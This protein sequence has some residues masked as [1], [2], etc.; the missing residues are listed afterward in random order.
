VKKS[1]LHYLLP[2][3]VLLGLVVSLLGCSTQKNTA[4]RRFYHRWTAYFNYYFNAQDAYH[5][6]ERNAN[7][8][9]RYD[10]TRPLPLCLA[11]LPEA[12]LEVGGGMDRAIDKCATLIRFH[13]ITAKPERPRG[14]LDREERAF[15]AQ[16]EYN[17]YARK[18]WLLIGKARLW[19]GDYQQAQQA[20]EFS[21]RQFA[22]LPEGWEAELWMARL[23]ALQ[24]DT[25]S[26]RIRLAALA[27]SP[28]RP[29]GKLYSYN[30][31]A[32]WTDML[33]AQGQW[34]EAIPHAEKALSVA[35]RG[36]VRNRCRFA[37]AQLYELDG[38]P[39]RASA[40]FK[41]VA[42]N[43]NSYEMS[44]NARVRYLALAARAQNRG[45]ER[46][47]RKLAADQKNEEYLDQI[48]YAL[49]RI[50]LDKGDTAEAVELFKE[51]GLRSV[52]NARQK[53]VS[54]LAVGEY[55]YAKG[56]YVKAQ[57]FYDSAL[58][59]LPEEYPG[60]DRL[61][62]RKV[63]LTKLA[64][65]LRTVEHE[66]S[67]Q[68]VAQMPEA[69]RSRLIQ[70]L[71]AKV[72]E[73]ERQAKLQEEQEARD[74]QFAMENQ[75]RNPTTQSSVQQSGGT[76]YFYNQG[77]LGFGRTDFKL[78]WG[79]R[80]LE[81]NWRRKNKAT[82]LG[83]ATDEGGKAD[84]TQ[85]GPKLS[86]KDVAYYLRDLPLTDSACE[87]S[88]TRVMAALRE[89]G[90]AY[91]AEVHDARKA[92]Q[93]YWGIGE[94][95]PK[96]EEAA[97]GYY[98]AYRTAQQ[99]QLPDLEMQSKERLMRGYP[100]SPYARMVGDPTYTQQLLERQKDAEAK[101][102][103]ALE[104]YQKGD[105]ARA[106]LVAHEALGQEGVGG[107]APNFALLEAL[108]T[109]SEPGGRAMI[110]AL[111]KVIVDYPE[112]EQATYA[113][114][115]IRTVERRTLTGVDFAEEL[116]LASTGTGDS[117]VTEGFTASD[118]EYW[119]ALMVPAK[120]DL[121]GLVFKTLGFTVDYNVD[122]NLEVTSET[123]NEAMAVVLVKTFA[124]RAAAVAFV[125]ALKG[126]SLYEGTQPVPVV[127]SPE[128]YEKMKREGNF[129][130]YREFYRQTYGE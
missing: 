18:G 27:A 125:E 61:A 113:G 93:S 24:G 44:F 85:A 126:K 79:E 21:M 75:Y 69:E 128:N 48:Y 46:T 66:D 87:A 30:L 58:S 10:Y 103:Q 108:C 84:S 115:V 20:L 100:Q 124:D 35:R 94:R 81:D 12:A 36:I 53:G 31:E 19:S 96:T 127:I 51:S 70:G 28:S 120:A 123:Y 129:M 65:A 23:S 11:G 80:K 62:E 111:R 32:I 64:D 130:G 74:R 119:V 14:G 107:Y 76:W 16:S 5:Q 56:Q 97:E 52:S 98:L 60:F 104:L 118:G 45:M 3:G 101:Y 72:Q 17:P 8:Q 68:R 117:A 102:Q 47:L 78:R 50:V 71:I 9:L 116:D 73:Q 63:G 90:D 25:A 105:R 121:T 99:A 33:A 22:G 57:A 37:L 4:W 26:A 43:A 91:S 110:Q 38:N 67:L 89:A 1:W 95:Y 54:Y 114:E 122:L 34:A 83:A 49:A 7:E 106:G 109:G 77:T 2:A 39:Q 82:Q 92:V 15:Y 29:K 41:Q 42:S 88:N 112:S 6:A 86:N 59:A 13:S 40:L 55:Y